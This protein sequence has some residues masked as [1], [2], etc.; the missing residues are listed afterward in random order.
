[1]CGRYALHGPVSRIREHFE[2]EDGFGFEPRY[3]IAPTATVLIV[4][5]GPHD[6]RLARLHRWGLIPPW[7]KDA[8][9]GAK[10]INAR[11]ETVAEKPAFRTAFRRWR[12]IVPASGFYE[13]KAAQ[14]A[15]RTIRQPYFVRPADDGDLFGFAGLSERWVSPEGDEVHTCCI[16]TTDANEL[17]IPLHDRMPVILQASDYAA[18]LDPGNA[19][20][21]GSR[22]LLRP[23][24]AAGMTAYKVCRAVNS[25]RGESPTFV[26]PI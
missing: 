25:S 3:N 4:K 19:D 24:A 8:T 5:S 15:G 17:M 14:E 26:E 7:A 11:G 23:A 10:L 12:C 22:R 9:I 13:W 20:V 6:K 18:W 21:S 2:L 1:M 16:I